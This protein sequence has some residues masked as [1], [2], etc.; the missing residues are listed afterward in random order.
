[1]TYILK[2]IN[3]DQDTCSKCGKTGLKRVYWLAAVDADGVDHEPA[4][5]GSDCAARLLWPGK[6][7]TTKTK[8]ENALRVELHNAVM[9]KIRAINSTMEVRGNSYYIPG[10]PLDVTPVDAFKM[11]AALYPIL[12]FWSGEISLYAAARYL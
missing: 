11:R 5:Y 2:G 10:T 12:R 9:G 6:P 7:A 1:M 4:P 8:R 3:D